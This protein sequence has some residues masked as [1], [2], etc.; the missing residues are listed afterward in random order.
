MSNSTIARF[1]D[2][3]DTSGE[4]WEWTAG[5]FK[6]G[7]GAFAY[8]DH[9]PGYAHRFSYELHHGPIPEG[10]VVRHTC[11]NPKCVNPDHLKVG[12]QRDNIMDAINRDRWMTPAR[13]AH[14]SKLETAEREPDGKF[15]K[16]W[17]A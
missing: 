6:R 3:V 1:W 17:A 5:C 4:C 14:L 16:D 11:D 9:R 8:D 12:T 7:Y 13:E 15:K 10:K 2:K